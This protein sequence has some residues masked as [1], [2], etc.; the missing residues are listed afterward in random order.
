M[1]LS[2]YQN[3]KT[4][5]VINCS[6]LSTKPDAEQ[7]R[8]WEEQGFL[9]LQVCDFVF[10][11]SH[12]INPN[13]LGDVK[14]NPR[15]AKMSLQN[16]PQCLKGLCFNVF[17]CKIWSRKLMQIS[18]NLGEREREKTRIYL[19]APLCTCFPYN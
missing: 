19:I 15:I 7:E 1:S 10:L 14:G 18:H 17:V 11:V 9:N 13:T 5:Q 6:W 3:K 16:E 2:S 4:S 12:K 8:V